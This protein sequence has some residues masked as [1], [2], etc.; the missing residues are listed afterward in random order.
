VGSSP[1]QRIRWP[2]STAAFCNKYHSRR[3]LPD[4]AKITPDPGGK[5][6]TFP[7]PE[8]L[9][10]LVEKLNGDQKYAHVARNWE[11]DILVQIDPGVDLK[12]AV[13]FYIDLWHGKCRDAYP[14]EIENS[15]NA[16]FRLKAPYENYVR[17]LKG[18]I[19]PMQALLTRKLGLS[20]NMAVL[21]RNVPT[22][23]DFVRCCREVTDAFL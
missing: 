19:E 5:V 21:M 10:T 6:A 8:W 11:G 1:T 9:S 23:L 22:V 2:P 18:E 7:T 15:V 16:A 4:F 17:L 14:V 13:V 20:G 3:I 12:D